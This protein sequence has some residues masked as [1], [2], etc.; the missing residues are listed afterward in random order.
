MSELQASQPARRS[1][2]LFNDLD[3]SFAKLL[4]R[5]PSDSERQKLYVVRDALGL[6]NNDALWLV[7]MALQHYQ[8]QYEAFPAAISQ[9]AKETLFALKETADA[10]M[11][12][13]ANAAKADLAAAVASAAQEVRRTFPKS[14]CGNGLRA[15]SRLHS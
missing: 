5:Q 3:E 12:M 14:K 7:L 8:T 2:D 6:E 9:A 13:S 4:G 1:G 15:V 10:T 11:R